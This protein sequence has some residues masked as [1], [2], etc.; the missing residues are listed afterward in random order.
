MIYFLAMPSG[1]QIFY[2]HEIQ[3]LDFYHLNIAGIVHSILGGVVGV[4]LG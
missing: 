2:E 1:L 3:M 4:F